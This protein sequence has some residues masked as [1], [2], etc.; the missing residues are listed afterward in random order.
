MRNN[1]CLSNPLLAASRCDFFGID[2]ATGAAIAGA[3]AAVAGA[4]VGTV[5]L[6]ASQNAA[7]QSAANAQAVANYNAQVQEQNAQLAF[8]MANYQA[9]QNRAIA[10]QQNALIQ[11]QN[12]QAQQAATANMVLSRSSAQ[13]ARTTAQMQMNSATTAEQQEALQSTISRANAQIAAINASF[14]DVQAVAARKRYE[15]G[16]ENA[17]QLD[18]YAETVRSQQR[19]EAR[20]MREEADTRQAQIRAKYAGS[21]VTFEGSPLVVLADAARLDET[22]VQDAAFASEL[23]ARKQFRAGELAKFE[24]G[25]S[26][27]DEAGFL[28]QAAGQR[29]QAASFETEAIGHELAGGAYGLESLFAAYKGQSDAFGYQVEALNQRNEAASAEFATGVQ[30]AR[31]QTQL[32]AVNYDTLIAG[33]RNKIALAEADLTRFAGA[34]QAS[35]IQ[36]DANA[37]LISGIGSIASSTLNSAAT[38]TKSLP[39]PR[40]TTPA[41]A[42]SIT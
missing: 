9:E 2:L 39:P 11:Q 29:I 18:L 41:Y 35:A 36:G 13:L 1:D 6:V 17:K 33:E 7:A 3:A 24:A 34:A 32:E 23:E 19:E 12:T 4:A 31:Y 22:R 26:L 16:L 40:T 38:I 27:I 21:G 25:F 30:E 5:G 37:S 42:G 20:R 10:T 15:A 8:Q 28:N 14:S